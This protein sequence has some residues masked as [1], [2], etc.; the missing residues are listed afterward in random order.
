MLQVGNYVWSASQDRTIRVWHIEVRSL[1]LLAVHPT[2]RSR[3]RSLTRRH[4][5]EVIA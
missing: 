5:S 1:R 2:R 3:A 4:C